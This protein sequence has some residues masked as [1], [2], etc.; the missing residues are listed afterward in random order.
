[1]AYQNLVGRSLVCKHGSHV[2][3][4][5]KADWSSVKNKQLTALLGSGR[6]WKTGLLYT[7]QLHNP[8]V[9]QHVRWLRY[10]TQWRFTLVGLTHL[11]G[12]IAL[13]GWWVEAD[14]R[15]TLTWPY[16]YYTQSGSSATVEGPRDA[17]CRSIFC[18]LVH[19]YIGKIS[20]GKTCNR[21]MTF[22]Y[23]QGHRNCCCEIGYSGML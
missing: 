18:Q 22:K 16:I 9:Q 1:M 11:L 8:Y 17:L 10:V 4:I 23:T 21:T 20:R 3:K 15:P 13:V 5:P 2:I 12:W 14:Q 7:G 6:P 19:K